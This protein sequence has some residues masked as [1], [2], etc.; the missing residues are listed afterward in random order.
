MTQKS[1]LEHLLARKFDIVIVIVIVS[2]LLQLIIIIVYYLESSW[3]ACC[4][5]QGNVG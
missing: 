2:P 4:P 3:E 1:S 5:M